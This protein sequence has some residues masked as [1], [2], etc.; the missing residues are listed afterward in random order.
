MSDDAA[1]AA[2]G[3]IASCD[4]ADALL[5]LGIP[6]F[7][8]HDARIVAPADSSRL[9]AR[10]VGRAHTATYASASAPDPTSP[11]VNPVDSLAPGSV[12]VVAGV[13]GSPNAYF[14]GLLCARAVAAG[15]RGAVVDGR[16]RDLAEICENDGFVVVSTA[17]AGS[18]LGAGKYAKCVAVGAPV[19]LGTKLSFV[20][21]LL[22]LC[23]TNTQ[24]LI[25][26]DYPTSVSEGDI[27][28]ADVDGC[29]IVPY[30]RAQE[31]AALA[32]TIQAQDALC[33]IDIVQHGSTL[34]NA[35]KN[36]RK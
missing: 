27:V 10:L 19:T 26:T 12:L 35:F 31:V 30:D 8:V 22:I 36:H 34:V 24:Q 23:V 29:V 15:A 32:R 1:V 21:H 28:V 6:R 3:A 13:P 33:K 7:F 17:P 18:V 25:S 9:A 11:V 5:R 2:V 14:G 20:C 4:L 16:V